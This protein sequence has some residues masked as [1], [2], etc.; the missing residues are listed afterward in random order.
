VDHTYGVVAVGVA[1]SP[2]QAVEAEVHWP[3]SGQVHTNSKRRGPMRDRF[4]I[5]QYL[6]Q[7]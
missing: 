3:W 5:P 4:P 1:D 2:V 7:G 6:E